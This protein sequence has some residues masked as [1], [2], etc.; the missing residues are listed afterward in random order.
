MKKRF[1]SSIK[2]FS[3]RLRMYYLLRSRL[4]LLAVGRDFYCGRNV[5]I[6]PNCVTVGDYVFFGSGCH[7]AS[8]VNIGNFV[9]F[10]SQVAVVGGD[11]LIDIPGV[12]MIFAGRDINR[13]VTIGD[14]V[15]IGHGAIIIHGVTIGEGAIVAAG[16]V[17]TKDVPPYT[18]FAGVPAVKM[19][20]RFNLDVR[21]EHMLVLARYREDRTISSEWH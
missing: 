6:R 13:P 10:A 3:K 8:R 9:M 18:V 7:I 4:Q 19:R 15:W 21:K 20:D 14:D 12:P 1:S 2:L 17:V 16:A 11:H 5:H